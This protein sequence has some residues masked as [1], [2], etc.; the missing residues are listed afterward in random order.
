MNNKQLNEQFLKENPKIQARIKEIKEI[1]KIQEQIIAI[2]KKL[3]IGNDWINEQIAKINNFKELKYLLKM[4]KMELKEQSIF[5]KNNSGDNVQLIKI[6]ELE[7]LKNEL[8][9]IIGDYFI[10]EDYKNA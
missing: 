5:I 6:E 3:T 1:K 7:R 8:T 2:L 10:F 9:W 4:F